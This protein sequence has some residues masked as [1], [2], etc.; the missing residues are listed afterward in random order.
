MSARR[1]LLSVL[2]CAFAARATAQGTDCVVSG[3]LF[4]ADGTPAVLQQVPATSVVKSGASF[5]I[6]PLTLSTDATGATTF[7]VP[8]GSTLW[9]AASALGLPQQ[10][11][12]ALPIP[13]A[14]VCSLAA[15]LPAAKSPVAGFSIASGANPSLAVS[16]KDFGIDLTGNPGAPTAVVES[17]NG[18]TGAVTLTGTDV[19][20]ALGYMPV[21][22]GT[23]VGFV[24]SSSETID[25]ARLASEIVR[26][27]VANVFAVRQNLQAGAEVTATTAAS[28]ALTIQKGDG[29]SSALDIRL[30]GTG[31][32][33]R[34][35]APGEPQPRTYF[36]DAGMLYTNGWMVIS[37]TYH[38]EGDGYVIDH[39]S[40][41]PAMLQVWSDVGGP[42]V[43]LRNSSAFGGYL[44]SGLDLD[45]N[46]VFS[47]EGSGSL[48]WG[49]TTRAGMDTNLYRMGAGAL[50]TDGSLLVGQKA[51][52]GAAD[53][54]LY[55]SAPATLKTDGTLAVGQSALI[56]QFLSV[57]GADTSLYRD[58]L[59]QLRTNASFLVDGKMS[60]GGSNSAFPLY[61]SGPE[62]SA[63]TNAARF[64]AG[65]NVDGGG[66]VIELGSRTQQFGGRLYGGR[67][68]SGD[69]GAR[70]VGVNSLGQETAWLHLNGQDSSATINTAGV[71]RVTV[72]GNG[73]VGIN[74]T[75]AA[76][77]L[78][79][80]NGGSTKGLRIT[81]RPTIGPPASGAWSAGTI[82]VDAAGTVY[83]CVTAGSPGAWKS[84]STTGSPITGTVLNVDPA[85]PSAGSWQLY[86]KD[87]G[88][89]KAQLC[90]AFSSGPPQCFAR[91]Q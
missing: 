66:S 60:V 17:F 62:S 37:G 91:Q 63:W 1:V 31:K 34:L 49:A 53:T 9:I 70:F 55:R 78:L 10:G 69:R 43:Q 28:S 50:R 46:H 81:P 15:L 8:K 44:L 30:D 61:V 5:V 77:A 18:R 80:I 40:P 32:G 86:A 16:L 26:R 45:A 41:E 72:K 65:A 3:A 68:G 33:L 76:D 48:R 90:V 87:D 24:N 2:L 4:K 47:I 42:A 38:G 36:N 23:V 56:S 21:D 13:D 74:T 73:N 7:A 14:L 58:S 35:F 88:T 6:T 20:D 85:P 11:D 29:T 57:G 22:P 39:P 83:I 82:V 52:F 71:D 27:D 64:D 12:L 84:L 19:S 54:S 79:E 51:Y 89:G 25:S 59:S 67:W 75:P